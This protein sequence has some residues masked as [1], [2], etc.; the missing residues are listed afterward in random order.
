MSTEVARRL[1]DNEDG[2]AGGAEATGNVCYWYW[3]DRWWLWLPG[4]GLA[5]LSKHTVVEHEDRTISVGPSVLV[6]YRTGGDSHYSEAQGV[7]V[8]GVEGSRH[9]F[10]ERGIW[11]DV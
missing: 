9:G 1:P 3:K 8:A 7:S 11:R 4:A 6:S 5:D 10:L 2:I